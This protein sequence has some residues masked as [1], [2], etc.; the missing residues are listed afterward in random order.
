MVF[1][2]Y[3]KEDGTR[4]SPYGRYGKLKLGSGSTEHQRNNDNNKGFEHVIRYEDGIQADFVI[5]S[6]SVPVNYDYTRLNVENYSVV[7]ED[8]NKAVAG[9]DDISSSNGIN[10]VRFFWDGGL[11]A[12]TPL[13][14]TVIAHRDYWYRVR[15]LEDDIP[16][17]KFGIINLHPV[18]Q[19]DILMTMIVLSIERM[20]SYIMTEQHLMKFVAVLISDY[21]ILAKSIIKLAEENGVSKKKLQQILQEE[22]KTVNAR[23]GEQLEI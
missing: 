4:K 23:T 18:K 5:A 12:N 2:S 21:A 9:S 16:R 20:T 14:Q 10:S 17:L 3:E 22:T 13:R 8:D 1:D 7:G 19:E 15:K 11:L 6:C